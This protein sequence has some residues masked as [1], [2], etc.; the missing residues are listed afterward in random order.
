MHLNST[1]C[2]FKNMKKKKTDGWQNV[3]EVLFT[4]QSFSAHPKQIQLIHGEGLGHLAQA[5]LQV[6]WRH[7]GNLT[8]E[9]E[10][11]SDVLPWLVFN[12]EGR[13]RCSPHI[14]NRILSL[15]CIW[16]SSIWT[17]IGSQINTFNSWDSF[18][19]FSFTCACVC[20]RACLLYKCAEIIQTRIVRLQQVEALA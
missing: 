8:H 17:G 14:W 11:L 4:S 6:H 7:W 15:H 5:F 1:Y 3:G 13:F 19:W 16:M 10:P 12:R 2:A 20:V 9:Q 18:S